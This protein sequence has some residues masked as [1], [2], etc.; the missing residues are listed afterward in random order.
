MRRRP[1]PTDDHRTIPNSANAIAASRKYATKPHLAGSEGDLR[2]AMYFFDLLRREFSIPKSCRDPIYPA[3][4]EA[5]RNATLSIA[6][7]TEPAAWID[8]YYP[9]LN[10]PLDRSLEILGDDGSTVW[11]AELEESADQLDGDAHT[12]ADSVGAW[13]GLSRDGQAEG[14]LIYA[15]YGT[16]S[17][18][19]ELVEKGQV[20]L[21]HNCLSLS[22]H[23][24]I[25][26]L[27]LLVR[28]YWSDMV[29]F[30]VV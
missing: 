2:T 25:Q 27:T 5:S 20:S 13:H 10:T 24:L 15:N 22:Y 11:K 6:N 3:G 7:L 26:A 16:K 14:R 30:S 28:L 19:D 21:Y 29:D 4:S 1:Q 12:Y 23:V 18:Y 9:I 17:D 8:V